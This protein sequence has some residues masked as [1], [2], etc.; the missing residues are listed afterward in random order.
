MS[1][2]PDIPVREIPPVDPHAKCWRVIDDA[3]NERDVARAERDKAIARVDRLERELSC[4][5]AL[6]GL[7][8]RLHDA[9]IDGH[10]SPR[11]S[12]MEPYKRMRAKLE[13]VMLVLDEVAPIESLDDP[14][15]RPTP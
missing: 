8:S 12:G 4:A 13:R 10:N 7:F 5:M 11:L 2:T 14:E 9:L 3:M 15:S 6:G 1:D